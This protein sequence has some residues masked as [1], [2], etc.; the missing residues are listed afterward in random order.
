[1]FV[2]SP[3]GLSFATQSTIKG[4]LKCTDS[5]EN[6][7]KKRKW[8]WKWSCVRLF[9]TPWTAAYQVS[10]SME[11]SRQEYWS[12]LPFPSPSISKYLSF[13]SFFFK[14]IFNLSKIALQCCVAFCHST[15]RISHI[16][17]CVCVCVCVY[18]SPFSLLSLLPLPHPIPLGHHRAPGWTP[19]VT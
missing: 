16:H 8:K 9:A 15:T 1:M 14:F 5:P 18:I 13:L 12:G 10:L 11:F 3:W 19:C 4:K 17:I 2:H 6:T 7:V